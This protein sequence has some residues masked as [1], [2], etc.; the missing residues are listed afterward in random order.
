[1]K[2]IKGRIIT[3]VDIEQK[4]HQTF[5]NGTVIRMERDF[6]NLDKKY[7]QQVLGEVIDAEYIPKGAMVLFHH[8]ATHDVNVLFNHGRLSGEEIKSGIKIISLREEECFLWKM[9][10]EP[11]WHPMKNF[12]TA[13]RVFK[14]YEGVLEGIAPKL[15]PNVLFLLDGE[16]KGYVAHV[17]KAS[18]YMI[19]FRNEQ[20]VDEQIIRMRHFDDYNDREEIVAISND[21]TKKVRNKQLLIGYSPE[22]CWN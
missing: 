19:T 9:P 2:H 18:D 21:L 12:C 16:Y 22:N 20:G 15:I 4:N 6:N 7:T 13:L 8:N 11:K 1:M 3:K 10:G 5:S 14:P 17:M